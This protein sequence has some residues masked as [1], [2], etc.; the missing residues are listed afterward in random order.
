MAQ[1]ADKHSQWPGLNFA[2]WREVQASPSAIAEVI[3]WLEE[4]AAEENWPAKTLFALTLCA[5]EALTNITMHAK[6]A[7]GQ[8]LQIELSLGQGPDGLFLCIADNGPEFDPTAKPTAELARTLD[9]A[10]I[11]GHGLRLMR[12][13]LKVFKHRRSDWGN[14]LLM[15]VE[16]NA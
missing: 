4:I 3:T 16:M 13:Y 5:D 1:Y 14:Q 9:E 7:Q 11:G 2:H 15:G 12:N 6:P 8:A 10:E